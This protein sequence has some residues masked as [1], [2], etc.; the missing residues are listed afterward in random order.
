[1]ASASAW[2]NAHLGLSAAIQAKL[3]YSLIAIL[4]V[5]GVRRA[6]LWTVWRRVDDVRSRYRWRKTITYVVVVIGILFVGRIWFPGF[7]NVTTYLGLLSAGIAIALKDPLANLAG[8]AFILWRRPFEVGDR[9]EIG[10]YKGDVIDARLFQF[11]LLE[12]GN[13]VN[14]DQST[15]RI[16]HV[17]NGKVLTDVL[18]NYTKGF[19][20]I[21]HEIPVMVTFESNWKKAK[22][23]L[24]E[25]AEEHGTHLS[26]EA[27]AQLRTVSRQFMIFYSTL[28]PI[29][30]T[31]VADSGVVL[32]MRFLTD[33]R[34][35][36]GS[37]E[38]MWEAI[39]ERFGAEDDIDLAYPTRRF[40]N[41]RIEGK[42]G[43][44]GQ[45]E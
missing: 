13:W 27:E 24:G 43:A 20:Y 6:V 7:N 36:R 33:A 25:V 1:M 34:Q 45:R 35:R 4:I 30:Y 10:T 9:I 41:N 42:P 16:I 15:G 8:W 26:H 5:W 17:P 23:I 21:W 19:K 11:S 12:I 44:G 22:Q 31:T 32:T 37:E 18:A 14:A 40:Y 2:L 28:T 3:V 39:L 38:K 29:V